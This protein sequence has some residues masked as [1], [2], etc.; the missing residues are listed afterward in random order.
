VD[1][2]FEQL[3]TDRG[4]EM[5]GKRHNGCGNIEAEQMAIICEYTWNLE[6]LG[7]PFRPCFVLFNEC[8]NL[9]IV[10]ANQAGK[11]LLFCH[12]TATNDRD[13]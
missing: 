6:A 4:V 3:N 1:A 5:I 11:M 7:Q 9:T 13:V 2:S 8:N 10:S 12:C